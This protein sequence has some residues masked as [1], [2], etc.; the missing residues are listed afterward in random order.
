MLVMRILWRYLKGIMVKMNMAL[1]L[2]VQM[3]LSISETCSLVVEVFTT[4]F[5]IISYMVLSKSMSMKTVYTT[6]PI[7]EYIVITR[8]KDLLN[9]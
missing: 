4:T 6:I 9:F 7:L 3:S 8:F 2:T 1:Y 5:T